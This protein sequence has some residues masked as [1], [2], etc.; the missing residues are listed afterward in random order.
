MPQYIRTK[1]GR[2]HFNQSAGR[3][4]NK[5]MAEY[6]FDAERSCPKCKATFLKAEQKAEF[7]PVIVVV[8]PKCG[9]ILWRPG[10]EI[11]SPLFPFNP[12]AD[13]GGL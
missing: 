4:K 7:D 12:D 10:S 1:G 13:K 11:N 9:Q 8:C 6:Q 3:G 5:A 2:A